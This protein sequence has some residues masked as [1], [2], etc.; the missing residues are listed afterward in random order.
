MTPLERLLIDLET[1]QLAEADDRPPPTAAEVSR[2][3]ERATSLLVQHGL[4]A[5]GAVIPG[6]PSADLAYSVR[7]GP[8][9][10][11]AAADLV[12]ATVPWDAGVIRLLQSPMRADL[13]I[14]LVTD[15]AREEEFA[16]TAFF[17]TLAGQA[18][19][20]AVLPNGSPVFTRLFADDFRAETEAA[21]L[22][23]PIDDLTDEQIACLR[24]SQKNLRDPGSLPRYREAIDRATRGR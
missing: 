13:A 4:H 11:L 19:P 21:L 24:R 14:E 3:C 12:K 7:F 18:D 20:I 16:E 5:P 23:V 6:S 10:T 22:G 1:D 9:A 17:L 2:A 8:I 15:T